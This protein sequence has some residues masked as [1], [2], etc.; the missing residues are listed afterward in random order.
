MRD[1]GEARSL[2]GAVGSAALGIGIGVAVLGI[3]FAVS[4][5]ALPDNAAAA[6]VSTASAT[7]VRTASPTARIAAASP[8]VAPSVAPTVAPAPTADPMVVEAA[9]G[10]GLR[11]A[12]ITI[13]A[14]YTFTSP[15]AGTVKILRYQ[16]VD[17][18]IRTGADAAG[19][20]TYPYIFVTSA[21]REIKLR[22][23]AIDRDIRL[24]VSDGQTVAIGAPLFKTIT[25]G[26][27]SWAT[28][29]DNTVTAQVVASVT[30]QPSGNEID[31]V[32]AFKR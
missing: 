1:D 11:L 28:F 25:T 2:F 17:G 13:P 10:Q 22:P 30:A 12:A 5:Y 8:T 4:R 21:T 6:S 20:P 3:G 27:S 15:I 26:A 24:L 23:G 31:P 32:P 18:E 29:Y 14:G 9:Q 7:P 19:E 16:F